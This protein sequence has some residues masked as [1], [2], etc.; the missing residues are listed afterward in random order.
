[1]CIIFHKPKNI[2]LPNEVLENCW[3]SNPHGAGFMV[4]K[5]NKLIVN[6]GFFSLEE[7][8]N[9]YDV[10]KTENIVAHFRWATHGNKDTNNCHPFV[11]N[12]NLA[13]AHNGVIHGIHKTGSVNSDTWHFNEEII[14]PL[15]NEFPNAWKHKT[16]K[17]LLQEKIGK[18]NKLVFLSADGSVSIY[19][20]ERGE[21]AYG[22]WFSNVD[23]KELRN[24]NYS[25]YSRYNNNSYGWNNYSN[26]KKAENNGKQNVADNE[27]KGT[28]T[29]F[30]KTGG[31]T[32]VDVG[33]A[34]IE[35]INYSPSAK[36]YLK[37]SESTLCDNCNSILS[38]DEAI[39]TTEMVLCME[40]ASSGEI[41]I[42]SDDIDIKSWL[43]EVMCGC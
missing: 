21:K 23:Y 22:C 11:V 18:T 41:D 5:D 10:Y 16:L 36:P 8:I 25:S 15:V 14:K 26:K 13:F 24:R 38:F 40:C 6:K 35:Q 37:Q 39:E 3:K 9:A 7:F 34:L 28:T 33:G 31:K 43:Q 20:E 17:F 19:N 29:K 1:M 27:K 2:I 12:E 42:N 30:I 32:F 4:A